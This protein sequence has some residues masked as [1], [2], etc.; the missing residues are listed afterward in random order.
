MT[1]RTVSA[2]KSGCLE[3]DASRTYGMVNLPAAG[4]VENSNVEIDFEAITGRNN[5]CAVA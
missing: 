1:G 3:T 5:L 2:I 4:R